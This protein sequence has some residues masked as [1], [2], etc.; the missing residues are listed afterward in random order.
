M[1]PTMSTAGAGVESAGRPHL[2]DRAAPDL[3]RAT[4]A[5]GQECKVLDCASLWWA[6]RA[7]GGMVFWAVRDGTEPS[8][9]RTSGFSAA[10]LETIVVERITPP[11]PRRTPFLGE[12]LRDAVGA[13]RPR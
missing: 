12:A 11:R 13:C 5:G 8:I 4:S 10:A 7:T 6:G 2:R 9:S 3:D 1:R